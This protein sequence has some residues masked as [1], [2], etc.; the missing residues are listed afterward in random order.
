MS[1]AEDLRDA[2]AD[3]W[4][5]FSNLDLMS[6]DWALRWILCASLM[7]IVL[8][9]LEWKVML[10]FIL[11]AVGVMFYLRRSRSDDSL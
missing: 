2:F 9:L 6:Q 4:D 10:P 3:S 1:I 7:I 5:W 8:T 11:F